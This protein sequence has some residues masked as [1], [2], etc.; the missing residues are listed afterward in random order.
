MTNCDHCGEII[1]EE[2]IKCQGCQCNYHYNCSISE[3]TYRAKS[4]EARAAWRCQVCREK[5]KKTIATKKGV[6]TRSQGG[7]SGTSTPG[8]FDEKQ[9]EKDLSELEGELNPS[10]KVL[11][12]KVLRSIQFMSNKFDE[13]KNSFEE[14]SREN[15]ALKNEIKALRE[16][17]ERKDE[18][19]DNLAKKI[20]KLEQDKKRKFLE[21][22][23]VEEVT[24][25]TPLNQYNNVA[26]E[27]GLSLEVSDVQRIKLKKSNMLLVKYKTEGHRNESLINGK[28][29]WNS[30]TTDE[31]KKCNRLFF[32]E[33]LIPAYRSIYRE[34]RIKGRLHN[35][36][37]VWV[38]NGR[39]LVRKEEKGKIYNVASEKDLANL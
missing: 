30:K 39:I 22:H 18:L 36:A 34:L 11:L 15:S 37:Y 6:V 5:I 20:N 27:V 13:M 24:D 8:E 2:E 32:N 1:T 38:K 26:T 29:W 3:T 16:S 33:S 9:L 17:V 31:K 23:G 19:I 4:R 7:S 14:N 10:V 21:I 35:Y 25:V 12:V 28:K